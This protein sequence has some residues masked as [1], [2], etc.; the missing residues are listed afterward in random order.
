MKKIGLDETGGDDE[1]REKIVVYDPREVPNRGRVEG[2]EDQEGRG[3]CA[4][5]EYPASVCNVH[6]TSRSRGAG[7]YPVAVCCTIVSAELPRVSQSERSDRSNIRERTISSSRPD[8]TSA[9]WN[10]SKPSSSE[11]DWMIYHR[12]R[13]SPKK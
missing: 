10:I 3:F 5:K 6:V 7:Y 4:F 9:S 13:T 1:S 11:C 12:A 2:R 8:S